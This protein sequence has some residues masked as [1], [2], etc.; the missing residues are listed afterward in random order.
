MS[1]EREFSTEEIEKM[2]EA[3]R[4]PLS[5]YRH[6]DSAYHSIVGRPEDIK[7]KIRELTILQCK[8]IKK[9]LHDIQAYYQFRGKSG[10]LK[11]STE[12]KEDFELFTRVMK[13]GGFESKKIEDIVLPKEYKKLVE[14]IPDLKEDTPIDSISLFKS[15]RGLSVLLF[16]V[17]HE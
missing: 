13:R 5:E 7:L 3:L 2:V 4:K 14:F 6:Y 10:V 15:I 9:K 12:I 1:K 17:R 11:A 8:K 16:E